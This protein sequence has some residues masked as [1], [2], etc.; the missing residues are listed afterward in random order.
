M[1]ALA[2]FSGGL[3]SMLAVE[4]I[5]AQGIDVLGLFFETPFFHADKAR[6]SAEMLHVPLKVLDLTEP[7][8]AI[9]KKP[10]YGYGGN[11]NPCIDCHSLM[12][13]EAAA[14][15]AEE[16]ARF[17][18]TGE[19]LGQ[20][21]MSQ[22]LRSLSTVAAQ[23]GLPEYILRPLSAKLLPITLPE[24]KGWVRREKLLA[25][26]GRS[27]KPQMELARAYNFAEYP[28][29]GGGCLLTD[30]VF[31]RRLKDLLSASPD[32]DIREIELLK[33]GRHFRLGP[34]TK[35]VV[36]R[37]KK[38]NEQILTLAEESDLLIKVESI[39]GPL[40]L[41]VGDISRQT[42]NIA[43]ALALSYSD[44]KNGEVA[45]VKLSVKGNER[46]ESAPAR[47]K[48]EFQALMI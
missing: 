10:R 32:C 12:I 25:L 1:K 8:L 40:A 43:L 19:V 7:H 35:I 6:R 47:S 9:V 16:N 31:S 4:L 42:E 26:S 37:N 5:Q 28:S 27:R 22:N 45:E 21:P 44:A 38:E 39:P 30:P 29:P 20:R 14:R 13:R 11:M 15:L 48:S 24:E 2:V 23:S 34:A 18:I 36:G 46:K 3:D 33:L 41:A 17:I